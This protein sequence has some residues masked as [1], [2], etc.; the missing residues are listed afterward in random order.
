M[1]VALLCGN[2]VKRDPSCQNGTSVAVTELRLVMLILLHK[3][4]HHMVLGYPFGAR[5]AER[6]SGDLD[7]HFPIIRWETRL[8]NRRTRQNGG[9]TRAM[10]EGREIKFGSDDLRLTQASAQPWD[11]ERL[12]SWPAD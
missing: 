3:L 5:A 8:W 4:R 12:C 7:S 6:N 10:A 11:V 1:A 2:L 9:P